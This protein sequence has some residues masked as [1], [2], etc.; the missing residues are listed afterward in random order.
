MN[1]KMEINK[2]LVTFARHMICPKYFSDSKTSFNEKLS[3]GA[4]G[5]ECFNSYAFRMSSKHYTQ[6]SIPDEYILLEKIK[7]ALGKCGCKKPLLL[8]SDGKDSMSLALA[9]KKAG[10]SVDTLTFL[11][12]DDHKLKEYIKKIATQLGHTSYF[13]DVDTII[14]KF[15][16]KVFL[17]S[18][19]K[20]PNLVMDQGYLF[21]L[22]GLRAFFD[23]TG[24]SPKDYAVVDGLGNDE[25]FGY[26]PSIDQVKSF[27]LSLINLWKFR[28][29][30]LPGLRWYIRSPAESHGD[31]SALSCF[32]PLKGSFSLNSFFSKINK[33]MN[34]IEFIDFRAFSRGSFHDHQCMMGKTRAAAKELGCE[35]YFPWV[36]EDLANYVFNLP[37]EYK[38]DFKLYEN[39][40]LLR[41]LL[42][43]ELNWSQSKRGVDLYFD[44]NLDKFLSE[45]VLQ[46]VPIDVIEKISK[47]RLLPL[48]VK[49]RA[50]LE[51][52]NFY[53]F[54]LGQGYNHQEIKRLLCK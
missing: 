37:L 34:E 50:S 51:L 22:F 18:C 32:F 3:V 52:M 13:V 8:L 21:F 1:T 30:S 53:G 4:A 35:V 16:S 27:K 40:I 54:C 33:S 29:N 10:V 6:D 9:Y 26:L 17:N 14:D 45:V 46:V 39:K 2:A 42:I 38:F 43:K 19:N 41:R 44:I 48:Y 28:P 47:N 5:L 11:R 15:D 24:F 23:E 12:K 31:L 20:M 49:K 36:D 25:T 7:T